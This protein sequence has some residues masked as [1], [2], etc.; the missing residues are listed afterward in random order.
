[1]PNAFLGELLVVAKEIRDLLRRKTDQENSKRYFHTTQMNMWQ[2]ISN[3]ETAEELN[4]DS[5]R[6]E[7]SLAAADTTT[8]NP[9]NDDMAITE[10]VN[11]SE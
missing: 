6:S 1:M 5:H 8:Q 3:T 9:H 11:G 7:D 4:T 2:L 10:I